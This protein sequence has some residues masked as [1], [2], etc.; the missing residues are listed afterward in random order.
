MNLLIL[1]SFVA[2]WTPSFFE[3]FQRNFFALPPSLHPFPVLS[4]LGNT[5]S[6]HTSRNS[7]L[8]TLTDP[9]SLLLSPRYPCSRLLT[10]V[11]F[12]SVC[13]CAGVRDAWNTLWSVPFHERIFY[14][15]SRCLILL[16][17][18]TDSRCLVFFTLTDSVACGFF[19]LIF[20]RNYVDFCKTIFLFRSFNFRIP[21]LISGIILHSI[22]T[23]V[24]KRN[25]IHAMDY[26]SSDDDNW[27]GPIPPPPTLNDYREVCN[28][29]II[30]FPHHS[31]TYDLFLY[32]DWKCPPLT[33]LNS[34][35]QP[36]RS[37]IQESSSFPWKTKQWRI[38]LS[39][40]R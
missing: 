29:S 17:T 11:I 7:V 37:K 22:K 1:L 14:I 35:K 4:Y 18:L 15:W 23:P 5:K 34:A 9:R 21:S 16:C 27:M 31:Y 25:N 24:L 20:G 36:T 13:K 8:F 40:N 19:F 38:E 6:N 39:K 33:W 12:I 30:I 28:T 3:V 26:S 2:S 32:S 10:C